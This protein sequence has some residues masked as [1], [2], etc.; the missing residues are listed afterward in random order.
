MIKITLFDN[1]VP[2]TRERFLNGAPYNDLTYN[3][4]QAKT[5]PF[6]LMPRRKG[7]GDRG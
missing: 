4:L 3:F 1:L 7:P 5:L 6:L 2:C